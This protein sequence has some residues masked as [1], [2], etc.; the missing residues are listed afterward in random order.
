MCSIG[1]RSLLMNHILG[2]VCVCMM[3][4]MMMMM[5]KPIITTTIAIIIIII[6]HQA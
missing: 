6:S 3:M 5:I 2:F 1:D 4:M